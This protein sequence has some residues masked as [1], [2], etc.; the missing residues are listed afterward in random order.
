MHD[1]VRKTAQVLPTSGQWEESH[2]APE[3]STIQF[4]WTQLNRLTHKTPFVLY[5][6]SVL[7]L[8]VVVIVWG[9]FVSAS[10]SGDGCGAS[11]PLCGN[12]VTGESAATATLV[13]FT[14]R[15]TSGLALLAVVWL[16]VVAYQR[17][18]KGHRVRRAATLVGI[19]MVVESLLGASLVIFQ[20]VDTNLSLA[21]AFV[22]PI[23]LTNTYLLLAACALTAW[24]A[25]GAPAGSLRGQGRLA[26]LLGVGLLLFVLLG[27]F[28]AIASLASTIFP[29]ESFLQGVQKD[30]ARDSHYLIQLRIWHPVLAL[31]T[32]GY[33]VFVANLT[34]L[35]GRSPL[36][37][38][39]A[40]S[41]AALF[42]VQFAA[43]SL[44]AVLLTPVWLQLTHLL[45]ADALWIAAVLF[46]ASVLGEHAL[47][48]APAG[49]ALA[50]APQ[51]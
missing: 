36:T 33:M 6:W 35:A 48:V 42:V 8:N 51:T 20:W 46:S 2:P 25:S 22:Q 38:R 24:W 7:L 26:G 30:F 32:G 12:P 5:A 21:R 29:S 40:W 23:H 28:G 3:H 10:G 39:L 44:N 43:G 34:Q 45:L 47:T 27:A 15:L 18:P 13:E 9:G 37:R 4:M 41:V 11:W 31:L 17:Y 16:V 1:L 19:F 50:Q 14:H 49:P